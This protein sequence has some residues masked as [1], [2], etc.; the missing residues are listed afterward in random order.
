M[1]ARYLI[2]SQKKSLALSKSYLISYLINPRQHHQKQQRQAL[3]QVN[4]LLAAE[5]SNIVAKD[6]ISRIVIA[7]IAV[8]IAIAKTSALIAIKIVNAVIAMIEIKIVNAIAMIVIKIA[9]KTERSVNHA[10]ISAM[11]RSKEWKDNTG[12]LNQKWS[13]YP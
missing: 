10:V 4:D 7:T 5:T 12:S 8:A 2:P 1:P 6:V 13:I 9:N 11:R 3:A